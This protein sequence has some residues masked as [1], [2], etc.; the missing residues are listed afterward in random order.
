MRAVKRLLLASIGLSAA[1]LV[2]VVV[3]LMA[4]TVVWFGTGAD[5]S[6][7]FRQP[8]L[9]NSSL[10]ADLIW[11][12]GTSNA[13]LAPV[14][15]EQLTNAWADAFALLE[16]RSGGELVDFER[17]FDP[18]IA[19]GFGVEGE[20]AP[21]VV[22]EHGISL[23]LLSTNRQVAAVRVE[24]TLDRHSGGPSLV[25]VETYEAVLANQSSGWTI[26]TFNRV[27]ALIK[28]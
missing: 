8:D 3:V 6:D 26:I 2:A 13:Q 14:E 7:A 22:L 17:R 21:F 10:S 1:V 25:L 23:E 18:R 28:S 11:D 5:P 9:A 12:D 27:D 15:A 19:E 4:A 20:W 24:V 16:R